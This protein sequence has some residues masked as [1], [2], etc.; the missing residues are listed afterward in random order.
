[1]AN[2]YENFIAGRWTP[3]RSGKHFQRENPANGVT[4][5]TFPDSGPDDVA[6]AV[7]AARWCD[8]APRTT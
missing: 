1:M 4:I 8:V 7:A 3:P 6:D 5:G 2:T